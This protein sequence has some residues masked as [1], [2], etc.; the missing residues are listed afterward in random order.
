[1]LKEKLRQHLLVLLT[2]T[3]SIYGM[4]SFAANTNSTETNE[5]LQNQIRL[6]HAQMQQM[7]LHLTQLE[8][9][10]QQVRNNETIIAKYTLHHQKMQHLMLEKGR[11]TAGPELVFSGNLSIDTSAAD[12][13]T[14]TAYTGTGSNTM[15]LSNAQLNANASVAPWARGYVSLNDNFG[16]TGPSGTSGDGLEF[17][18]AYLQFGRR[19]SPLLLNIGKQYLPFGVYKHHPVTASLTQELSEFVKDAAVFGYKH[20][21]FFSSAYIFLADGSVNGPSKITSEKLNHNYGIEI[22]TIN[23]KER[24]FGYETS[25]GYISNL[26][27]ARNVNSIVPKTR[28]A[29]GNLAPHLDLYFG[30]L[31]FVLDYTYATRTFDQNDITMNGKSARPRAFSSEV[32]YHFLTNKHPST[33]AAGYQRSWDS[34]F[35]N[36]AKYRYITS[37]NY[38]FNQYVTLQFE[39]MHNTDYGRNDEASYLNSSGSTTTVSGTGKGSNSGTMRISMHF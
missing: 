15:K 24:G 28:H 37:Y 3:F 13:T 33:L 39:L 8:Q 29:V 35:L 32:H 1:M 11:H 19:Q 22:G 25:L 27:E 16:S 10:Y 31:N 38:N 17:E 4:E 23:K 18:Q 12:R 21:K 5:S 6:L 36:M 7:Q 9:K 26:A 34:L 14:A 30:K 2:S 20:K